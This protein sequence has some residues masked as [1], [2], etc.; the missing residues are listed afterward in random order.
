MTPH[1]VALDFLSEVI[2]SCYIY[3]HFVEF[4]A[5]ASALHRPELFSYFTLSSGAIFT[6]I[7]GTRKNLEHN[8]SGGVLMQKH[9]HNPEDE[10]RLWWWTISKEANLLNFFAQTRHLGSWILGEILRRIGEL[11]EIDGLKWIYKCA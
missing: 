4:W 7:C 2:H 10:M 8:V 3:Y 5:T 1:T 6:F 9:M 11:T